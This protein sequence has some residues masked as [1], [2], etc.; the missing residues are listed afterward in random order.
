MAISWTQ[1]VKFLSFAI[2]LCLLGCDD[3]GVSISDSQENV[4]K[5][6]AMYKQLTPK[7]QRVIVDKGTE[8]PFTGEFNDHYEKGVYTCRRCGE[9]LYNS[10][11]K[12]KSNCGWP[13]F[14][15][16][17][18]GA[19]KHIPDPDGIRTEIVCASCNGHLGHIFG[20]EGYTAKNVRH[21]VNS[22]SMDFKPAE[23][24]TERAIFA[25]GCFWG[26][27]YHFKRKAGVISTTVGYIG[28]NLD[29]PTYKQVCTDTTGHAEA[30]EVVYEPAKVSYGELT[31]L[32]FETHNF[33]QLNRQGPDVGTQYRSEIFYLSDKQ[34]QIAEDIIEQLKGKDYDVKTSVTMAA[35][36]WAGEGYHQDYYEKNGKTPYCHI[37]KKIF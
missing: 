23:A 26:V 20:G 34:K 9:E 3:R 31:K 13:S 28:G 27:E 4:D 1:F 18:K 32:F 36:F 5:E 25:S 37:Y 22:I 17:I 15:D 30:V 19:V 10:S 16:E 6:N 21:C 12:F 33:T 24:K 29:N 11:S 14:D 2:L 35:K 7:E 8:R